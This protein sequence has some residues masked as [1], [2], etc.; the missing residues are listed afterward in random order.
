MHRASRAA[1]D[2][3][4]ADPTPKNTKHESTSAATIRRNL[5][6]TY[7]FLIKHEISTSAASWEG[8][9]RAIN[10]DV[11]ERCW[12]SCVGQMCGERMGMR[13]FE[14]WNK[15]V[16][17]GWI[18]RRSRGARSTGRDWWRHF[19]GFWP[20]RVHGNFWDSKKTGCC[21]TNFWLRFL[22]QI[23]PQIVFW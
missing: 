17:I 18:W 8:N 22:P 3:I 11:C 6:R 21:V 23:N 9:I 1:S 5:Q 7:C 12:E 15:A 19:R 14:W 20:T 4:K 16:S 2:T 13:Q 10:S